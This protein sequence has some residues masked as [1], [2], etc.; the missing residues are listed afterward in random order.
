MS[1]QYALMFIIPILIWIGVAKIFL[2]YGISWK[3]MILQVF[4]TLSVIFGVFSLGFLSQTYD[5]MI[6]NGVVTKLDEKQQSCPRG[7]HELRDDFCTNYRTRQVRD[8]ET[9][10]TNSNG[11]R[12]CTPRYRTQYKYVYPWERRYYVHSTIRTY[13]IARADPQG[14]TVPARF[15]EIETGDPVS[16]IASYTNYIMGASSSLFNEQASAQDLPE[17]NYPAIYD[18]YRVNRLIIDGIDYDSKWY[19]TWNRQLSQI[20]SDIIETG[21]NVIVV[22]TN[23][24][25]KFSERLAQA[26]QGHN[27]NDVIVTIG[28]N[29]EKIIWAD[30]RSWGKDSIVN[31]LIRDGILNLT[32]LDHDAINE[33]I[34]TAVQDHFQ[35]Q[36]MEEFEYLA[37]DIPPP[38]WVLVLAF[39]FLVM[40][41]PTLTFLFNKYDTL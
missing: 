27:V 21:A 7:W 11:I 24:D 18:Y 36:S 37:D 29:E 28:V 2:H 6:V 10:T 23:Q 40:I 17:V 34:K 12:T 30:V 13:E 31:L 1:F 38:T 9:C 8:G 32:S 35:L 41:T 4:I 16:G 22:L 25:E 3:E 20:N 14:V 26:W 39:I 15:G 19:D 5:T 33:V